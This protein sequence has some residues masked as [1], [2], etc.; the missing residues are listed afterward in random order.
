MSPT[1]RKAMIRKDHAEQS[2]IRQCNLLKISRSSLS[3]TPVGV[4]A[5]TLKLMN[6]ANELKRRG[7]RD[8]LVLWQPPDRRILAGKWVSRRLTS[9][10]ASAVRYEVADDL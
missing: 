6:E 9:G 10:S 1:G 2:L 7:I 3:Y 4:N 8:I 5:E